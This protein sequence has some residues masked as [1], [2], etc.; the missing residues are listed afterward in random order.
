LKDFGVVVLNK[1][2]IQTMITNELGIVVL[3]KLM[4][5]LEPVDRQAA[6]DL[7]EQ[8]LSVVRESKLR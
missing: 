5:R 4:L 7:I 6:R 2:T 8:N 3:K 1:Q